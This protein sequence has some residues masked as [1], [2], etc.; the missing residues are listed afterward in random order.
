VKAHKEIIKPVDPGWIKNN[1]NGIVGFTT[2][3]ALLLDLDGTTLTETKT[4]ANTY[5]ERFNLGGYQIMRSSQNNYHIIFN[6][7]FE[8]K[9]VCT[10]LTKICWMFHYHK[11]G[12]KPHLTNWVILQIVKQS[13][14]LR[15]SEKGKKKPPKLICTKGKTDRLINDY[16]Q[17]REIV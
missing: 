3:N 4:I 14:T 16:N 6:N 1:Y 11:H 10:M 12:S 2:S 17:I 7:Y 15:I 5:L 9:D 8:W 13:C